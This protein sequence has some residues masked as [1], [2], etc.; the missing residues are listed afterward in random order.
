M[1]CF[2]KAAEE[3]AHHNFFVKSWLKPNAADYPDEKNRE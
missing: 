3:F 1:N 2:T